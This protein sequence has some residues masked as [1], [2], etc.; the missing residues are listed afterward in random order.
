MLS[1]AMGF[2]TMMYAFVLMMFYDTF[3]LPQTP[4]EAIAESTLVIMVFITALTT[5][6]EELI[7]ELK[8]AS[9][10]SK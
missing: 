3:G 2:T 7:K 10:K 1:F 5:K 4:T 6:V 8:D 9:G